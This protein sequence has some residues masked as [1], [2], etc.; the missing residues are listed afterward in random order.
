[1]VQQKPHRK[2]DEW[3]QDIKAQAQSGQ[4]AKAFCQQRGLALHSFYY[5]KQK[6]RE[7]QEPY[8]F[9]E[10]QVAQSGLQLRM[11]GAPWCVEIDPAFDAA[12]LQRVMRVLNG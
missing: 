1:M 8:G 12:S 4:T 2:H 5:H 9:V 7:L 3:M 11:D 10:V 6:T